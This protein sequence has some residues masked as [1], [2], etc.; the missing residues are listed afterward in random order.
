MRGMET[1][2]S[3]NDFQSFYQYLGAEQALIGASIFKFGS[4]LLCLGEL[5]FSILHN[6]SGIVVKIETS[7][8]FITVI[9]I[10]KLT[11]FNHVLK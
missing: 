7:Q 1:P 8:L 9:L 5:S 4:I 3:Y 6:P 11:V 10:Q 2:K